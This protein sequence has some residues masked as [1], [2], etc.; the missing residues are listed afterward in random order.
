MHSYRFLSLLHGGSCHPGRVTV[1]IARCRTIMP[2]HRRPLPQPFPVLQCY[3]TFSDGS[4]RHTVTGAS[5]NGKKVIQIPAHTMTFTVLFIPCALLAVYMMSYGPSEEDVNEEVRARYGNNV[6]V[7]E[8]NQALKEFFVNAEK[9]IED[10]RFQQVLYGG[11]GE[12]K[13]FHAVDKELY[14]TEQGV[15]V[16]QQVSEEIQQTVEEK[17]RRRKEKRRLKKQQ[18]QLANGDDDVTKDNN[19]DI[20]VTTSQ[21]FTSKVTNALSSVDKETI[22]TVATYSLIGTAAV[23]IGFLAG[24]SSNRRS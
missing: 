1:V 7:Q 24:S 19:S 12:K 5:I 14:G 3:R 11:K 18:Q 15:I 17:K 22:K 20:K 4:S 23:V 6:Q 9:G 8:K 16:K 21:S 2:Q 13:R 10:Q